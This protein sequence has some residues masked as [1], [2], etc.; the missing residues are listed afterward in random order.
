MSDINENVI[1]DV[2]AE[3][4]PEWNELS[5]PPDDWIDPPKEDVDGDIFEDFFLSLT[6][7]ELALLV[8]LPYRVGLWM[9][10]MDDRGGDEADDA[11]IKVLESIVFEIAQDFCKSQFIQVIM[12]WTLKNRPHWENWHV[13]IDRVPE[14][15]RKVIWMLSHKGADEKDIKSFQH[16]LLYIAVSVAM[17]FREEEEE[18]NLFSEI[19]SKILNIVGDNQIDYQK[20]RLKNI[21]KIEEKALSCLSS[22]VGM[23]Y[24]EV[25]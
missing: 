2:K 12:Q 10:E 15:C 8:P 9:S 22:Y 1:D 13:N 4:M 5:V 23:D 24:K 17:A 3:D 7:E 25:F 11:E 19:K 18:S 16:T 6:Q 20:E 21:S 14:E